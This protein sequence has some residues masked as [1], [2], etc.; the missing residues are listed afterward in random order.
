MSRY[1]LPYYDLGRF[2]DGWLLDYDDL[3]KCYFAQM[4]RIS[5]FA[6]VKQK[7]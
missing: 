2:T 7:Y 4:G 1:T 3:Q 5:T 6:P